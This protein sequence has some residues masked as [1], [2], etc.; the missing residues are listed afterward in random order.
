[1]RDKR[2]VPHRRDAGLAIGLVLLDHQQ[3]LDRS[4]RRPDLRIVAGVSERVE[5]QQRIHHR[6]K[7]RAEPVLS[8]QPLGDEG[9]GLVDRAGAHRLRRIG[10]KRR[11]IRS[12][13]P[14]ISGHAPL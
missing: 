14:K 12:M 5:H 2:R 1:M 3:F 11:K 8:I 10:L 7:N 6:R 13:P 4:P 9:D